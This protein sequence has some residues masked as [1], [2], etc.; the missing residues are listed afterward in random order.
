MLQSV[1]RQH[2]CS[3]TARARW[4]QIGFRWDRDGSVF[5]QTEASK[6]S[7][8]IRPEDYVS[9]DMMEFK[10]GFRSEKR[11]RLKAG[12]VPFNSCRSSRSFGLSHRRQ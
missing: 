11:V 6:R 8:T 12:V 2:L 5:T 7:G 3:C 10:M 4:I 9:G 1:R